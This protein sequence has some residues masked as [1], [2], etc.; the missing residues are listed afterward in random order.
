[1]YIIDD[2]VV[3]DPYSDLI[4]EDKKMPTTD[5]GKGRQGKKKVSWKMDT[6]NSRSHSKLTMP[7]VFIHI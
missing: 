2:W 4:L 5:Y 7:S 6:N 1:M 3:S